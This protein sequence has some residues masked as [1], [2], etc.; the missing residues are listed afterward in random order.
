[1]FG[2]RELNHSSV[3]NDRKWIFGELKR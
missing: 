3:E 1:M 2:Y